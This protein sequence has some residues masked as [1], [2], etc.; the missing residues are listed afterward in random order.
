MAGRRSWI[1]PV[2]GVLL[3]ASSLAAS[4]QSSPF[5]LPGTPTPAAPPIKGLQTFSGLSHEH[6]LGPVHYAQ[7][8]PAGGPHNPVWENCAFYDQP[9]P[10]EQAVHSQEHG[11]VWITYRPDLPADQVKSL[12]RIAH[13]H[14]YILVS[15]YPGL[16]APVVASAWGAQVKLDGV[17]D[18]RL[19][20]Y[21]DVYAG[22]GPERDAPCKG[23]SSATIPF[24]TPTAATPS[25]TPAP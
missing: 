1:V 13:D 3:L 19:K 23:G 16:S 9:V 18:P 14:D 15:P 17:D 7:N 6:V 20:Q 11:A 8:P 12:K 5:D 4:A 22:N 25:A 2:V 10:N 21:I 24:A